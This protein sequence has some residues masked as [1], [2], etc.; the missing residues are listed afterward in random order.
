MGEIDA[1]AALRQFVLANGDE[2]PAVARIDDIAGEQKKTGGDQGNWNVKLSRKELISEQLG[3]AEHHPIRAVASS[4]QFCT[5]ITT[6][7]P[8][9]NVTIET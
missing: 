8:K 3:R 4:Y 6:I 2:G 7:K 5:T 1:H 9:P